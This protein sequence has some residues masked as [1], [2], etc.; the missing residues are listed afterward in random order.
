MRYFLG[1]RENDNF[2]ETDA[3]A[4]YA[5]YRER[6]ALIPEPPSFLFDWDEEQDVKNMTGLDIDLTP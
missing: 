3:Q 5:R 1:T 2:T 6:L 4:M